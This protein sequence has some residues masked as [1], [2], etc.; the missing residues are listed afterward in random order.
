MDMCAVSE[1]VVIGTLNIKIW[2]GKGKTFRRYPQL[3][4][5][6][7]SSGDK[8]TSESPAAD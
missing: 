6:F 1:E 4:N 5:V 7:F 2:K 8:Q 3:K